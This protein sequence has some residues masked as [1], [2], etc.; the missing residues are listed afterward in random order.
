MF[1]FLFT[2]FFYLLPWFLIV[3]IA[4]SISLL[5]IF[6]CYSTQFH[7]FTI[8]K[9]ILNLVLFFLLLDFFF[10]RLCIILL[11]AFYL[12]FQICNVILLDFIHYLINFIFIFNVYLQ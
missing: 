12:T 4:Y 10:I 11:Y 8:L 2:I 9:C 7:L 5:F 1:I 3:I 6:L